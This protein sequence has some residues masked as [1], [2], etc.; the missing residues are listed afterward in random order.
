MKLRSM[1]ASLKGN[2]IIFINS[3]TDAGISFLIICLLI[4]ALPLAF[5]SG[6]FYKIA[7]MLS[8]KEEKEAEK[9]VYNKV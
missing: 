6:L 1:L 3:V 7:Q 9:V 2:L 4:I 8:I 5:I